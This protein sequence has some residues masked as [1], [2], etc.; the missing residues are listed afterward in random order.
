MSDKNPKIDFHVHITSPEAIKAIERYK[1]QDAYFNLLNASPKSKFA[2]AEDVIEH[3]DANGM[4]R[5]VVFGFAFRDQGLCVETNSYV[6]E[7][8]K[9]YPNRLIGFACV[10]PTQKGMESELDRCLAG[11]IVG[12]GELMSEGQGY[13]ID[14]P[15]Q[16]KDL[17][18]YCH[19][20]NL[21]LLIHT[22]ESLGHYYPGKTKTSI[23]QAYSFAKNNPDLT[24]IFAHWGGG[25]CFY[26]LMPELR[27]VL[28]NVYYDTAASPFLYTNKV[29]ETVKT[30]GILDKVL[31][32]SDYPLLPIERYIKEIGETN[33]T[34]DE[35]GKILGGNAQKILPPAG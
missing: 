11:G 3:L 5:A 6:L 22:N 17:T 32:G 8:I 18:G 19:E 2:T 4:D 12:V 21:P 10:N 9:K 35:K 25:L 27:K 33:L 31:F 26:E 7:S 1:E 15:K 30:I 13:H 34:G 23:N 14:D 16:M 20:R 24:I 28:K 29:Y